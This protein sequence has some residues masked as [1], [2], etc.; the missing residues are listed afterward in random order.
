M[1]VLYH[2]RDPLQHLRDLSA[3]LRSGGQL[4]LET[5]FLPGEDQRAETPPDRY[6]R[7]RNVWLLP[8][9][10][11]LVHWLKES[12]YVQIEVADKSVTSTAEQRSTTWMRFESL[13]DALDPEDPSLTVE[14]WPAPRRVVVTARKP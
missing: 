11:R 10:P 9:V 1:G 13:Q 7:M 12:G 5:L 8:T 6:A 3:T 4:V 14:G 2:Q